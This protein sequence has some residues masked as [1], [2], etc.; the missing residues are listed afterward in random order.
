LMA[1][2]LARFVCEWFRQPDPQVGFV[3]GVLSM[4]QVLS[5]VGVGIGVLV[6]YG[7]SR[8]DA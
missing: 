4:G 8:R 5:L 3:W 6:F 1:Y 2:S 7:C